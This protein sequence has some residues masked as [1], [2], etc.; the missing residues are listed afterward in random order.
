MA[1]EFK[2]QRIVEFVETDM[3]GILH[4]SNFFR[5]ME[6]AE[7]GF[8]RSMGL[9]VH[10]HS[11]SEIWGWARGNVECKYLEP[12]HYEDVVE[13]HLLVREKK[14]ASI[15]YEMVFRKEG[16]EVARGKMTVIC[17]AKS[18]SG[19]KI[20]ATTMPAEVDAA[21]QVAP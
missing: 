18:P 2:V 4:F 11:K 15:T 20:R 21:I 17:V 1:H 6:S 8:F 16:R 12:L 14:R 19:D 9:S 10:P 3:A 13:I 5:Y 7:H